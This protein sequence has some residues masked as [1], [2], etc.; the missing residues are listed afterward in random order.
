MLINT[1][2]TVIATALL[3]SMIT[4]I[5]SHFFLEKRIKELNVKFDQSIDRLGDVIEER[6]RQGV[7][8]GVSS[9]PSREVIRGTTRTIAKTGV[10]IVEDGLNSFLGKKITKKTQRTSQV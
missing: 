3:T 2:I 10:E 5:V 7:I 9:L 6:V 4:L 1:I 8:N